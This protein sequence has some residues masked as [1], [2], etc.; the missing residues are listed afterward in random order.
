M[1]STSYAGCRGGP[2]QPWPMPVDPVRCSV[3]ICGFLQHCKDQKSNFKIYIVLE[4]VLEYSVWYMQ[5]VS[6]GLKNKAFQFVKHLIFNMSSEMYIAA[7]FQ[8]PSL[9][10]GI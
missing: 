8:H 9:G 6:K 1:Q 5:T 7:F 4:I 3:Q 10:K 2:V